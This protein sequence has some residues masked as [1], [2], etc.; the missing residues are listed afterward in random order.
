MQRDR[1]RTD[2]NRIGDRYQQTEKQL[3]R[4]RCGCLRHPWIAEANVELA[5]DEDQ[6]EYGRIDEVTE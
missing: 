5:A 6:G 4:F 3:G 2:G 1:Q